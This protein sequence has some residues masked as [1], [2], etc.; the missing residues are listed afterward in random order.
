MN[1]HAQARPRVVARLTL[2]TLDCRPFDIAMSVSET[3]AA[4]YSPAV[5]RLR[6]QARATIG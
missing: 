4:V 2:V 6:D 5:L 1:R 3:D